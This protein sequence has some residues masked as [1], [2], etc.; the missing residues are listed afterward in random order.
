MRDLI[1]DQFEQQVTLL[2]TSAVC[3]E[4]G[5]ERMSREDEDMNVIG[6]VMK[7]ILV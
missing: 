4:M 3:D 7:S 2:V 1:F 5:L 6:N